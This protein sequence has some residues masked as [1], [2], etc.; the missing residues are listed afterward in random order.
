MSYV[1]IIQ[2]CTPLHLSYQ[3]CFLCDP[4]PQVRRL[5]PRQE[6][7]FPPTGSPVPFSPLRNQP[8]AAS[9]LPSSVQCGSKHFDARQSFSF[10]ENLIFQPEVQWK[11]LCRVWLFVTRVRVRVHGILQARILALVAIPFS[12]GSSQ[13][14]NWTRV[15]CTAGGFFINWFL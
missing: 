15:S 5:L 13:P 1:F 4:S 12:R 6:Y 3:G 2:T 11:S 14:R 9:L 8:T 7:L 10:I